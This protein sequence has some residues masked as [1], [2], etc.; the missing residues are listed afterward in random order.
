M[1]NATVA[2]L[3][4][5]IESRDLFLSR[6][7][8]GLTARVA[9]VGGKPR[10]GLR[11]LRAFA[12]EL[13]SE[14]RPRIHIDSAG[15]KVTGR[16]DPDQLSTAIAELVTNA[17]K[18]GAGRPITLELRADAA[19][20][21]IAVLDAG[22]GIPPGTRLGRRFV[23][24]QGARARLGFG[25]G[26]WLTRRIARAHGGRFSLSRRRKGGTRA[27]LVLPRRVPR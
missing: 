6:V 17:I 24:G 23:R 27:L 4:R 14:H 2:A 3:R 8:R 13:A 9:A 26:I 21:K 19:S 15:R 25:V 10:P 12:R 7:S 11:E 22:A 20:I 16:F 18:Y 5:E 1:V